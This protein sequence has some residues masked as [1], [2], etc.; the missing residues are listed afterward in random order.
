MKRLDTSEDNHQNKEPRLEDC[1]SSRPLQP[2]V[3]SSSV[4]SILRRSLN[5][6]NKAK[7]LL[8]SPLLKVH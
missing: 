3:G 6:Q 5:K 1:E 7:R 8:Q 4:K 2:D